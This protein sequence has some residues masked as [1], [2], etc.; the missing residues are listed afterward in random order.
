[1]NFKILYGTGHMRLNQETGQVER[2][3][4][5]RNTIKNGIIFDSQ[6]LLADVRDMVKREK[7]AELESGGA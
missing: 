3:K 1:M 6:E 4:A 2:I 5:L 7:D